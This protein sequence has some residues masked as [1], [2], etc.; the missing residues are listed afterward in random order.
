MNPVA[1]AIRPVEIANTI[2]YAAITRPRIWGAEATCIVASAVAIAQAAKTPERK[3]GSPAAAADQDAPMTPSE[4]DRPMAHA[5][6]GRVPTIRRAV[7]L[8]P[9]MTDPVPTIPARTA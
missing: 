4:A 1:G 7:I 9:P 3:S 5:A 2:V 8:R 6:T